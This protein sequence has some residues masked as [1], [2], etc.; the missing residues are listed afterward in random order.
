MVGG[1]P[2]DSISKL[3]ARLDDFKVG[4]RIHIMVNRDGKTRVVLVALQPGEWRP[5]FQLI[6][7]Q[8]VELFTEVVHQGHAGGD[9]RFL[10]PVR[11][12]PV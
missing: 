1:K 8:L 3:M 6:V 7:L 11:W 9:L 10:Y 2:V 4:D 5:S 12:M